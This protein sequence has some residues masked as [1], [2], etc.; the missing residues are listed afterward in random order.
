[1]RQRF[2]RILTA[3]LDGIR[4]RYWKPDQFIIFQM[5]ILQI[6]QKVA[7]AQAIQWHISNRMYMWEAGRHQILVQDIAHACDQYL[8]TSRREELEDQRA[9]TFKIIVL[10]GKL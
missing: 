1:M 9:K 3:E 10:H 7:D 8:F 2:V 6:A 4:E 5:M